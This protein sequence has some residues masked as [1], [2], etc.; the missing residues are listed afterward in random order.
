MR[1]SAWGY[2]FFLFLQKQAIIS[3]LSGEIIEKGA[4][5]KKQQQQQQQK[6]QNPEEV[7][8]HT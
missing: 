3:Y 8:F 5:R 7:I 6:Y 2:S 4:P 1:K